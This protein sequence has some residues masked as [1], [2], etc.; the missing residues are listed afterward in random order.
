[1]ASTTLQTEPEMKSAETWEKILSKQ[2][3]RNGTPP[4]MG[5][6]SYFKTWKTQWEL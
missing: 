2:F 1:M 5:T 4:I 6:E 3:S